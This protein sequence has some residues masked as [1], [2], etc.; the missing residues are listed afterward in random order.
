MQII[1]TN[2][3]AKI[4]QGRDTFTHPLNTI[5]YAINEETEGVTLFRNNEPIGTSPISKTTVNNE[6]LTRDNID[7]L[8]GSLFVSGS[9]GG[10]SGITVQTDYL[11]E[12]ESSGSYLKNRPLSRITK[13]DDFPQAVA[14][15]HICEE[16]DTQ[17][18]LIYTYEWDGFYWI[19]TGA[20]YNLVFDIHPIQGNQ[21]ETDCFSKKTGLT[22]YYRI[23]P[24]DS[25]GNF[26]ISATHIHKIT[27]EFKL[28]GISLYL[29]KD[30]DNLVLDN[31]D[32]RNFEITKE[33]NNHNQLNINN[34]TLSNG[35]SNDINIYYDSDTNIKK[36]CIENIQVF[37]PTEGEIYYGNL[38]LKGCDLSIT[39]NNFFGRLNISIPYLEENSPLKTCKIDISNNKFGGEITDMSIEGSSNYNYDIS[40]LGNDKYRSLQIYS[41]PT[42]NNLNIELCPECET[43]YIGDCSFSVEAFNN[44]ISA[45]TSTSF[46][47]EVQFHYNDSTPALTQHQI[48]TLAANNVIIPEY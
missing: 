11:E 8:L 9:Q 16:Y 23:E 41:L 37:V 32:V 21:T 34:L 19:K 2:K 38:Y 46:T 6:A 12:N 3:N 42:I 27:D 44:L 22:H 1:T 17:G 28:G 7:S 31:F 13:G 5:S 43:I 45:L 25:L 47:Q 35:K 33:Y 14:T 30:Y 20:D 40:L 24:E 48:D 18:K 10:S 26:S 36:I 4:K 39:N 29:T 15:G